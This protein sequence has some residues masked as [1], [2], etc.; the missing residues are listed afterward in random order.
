[1]RV[2][3]KVEVAVPVRTAYDQWTQFESFP[4]FM[5]LVKK[6]IQLQPTMTRWWVGRG[7]LQREFHAE[8]VEQ[9]PDTLVEWRSLDRRVPHRG[10]VAFTSVDDHRAVVSVQ[11]ELGSGL[12]ARLLHRPVRR[13]INSQLACFTTFI[14]GVGD[15][16]E[17][18]R[19][20]IRRGRVE[21]TEHEP[22]AHPGWVH[23]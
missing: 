1:M 8:I 13:M 4:R 2:D 16:G 9:H 15:A 14:E 22:P 20:T 3:A 12:L 7:P 6:V 11:F 5:P 17:T 23:G 19:G 21:H 18:W 10:E